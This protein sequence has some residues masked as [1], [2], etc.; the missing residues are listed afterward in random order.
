MINMKNNVHESDIAFLQSTHNESLIYTNSVGFWLLQHNIVYLISSAV[1]RCMTHN[2]G[3]E[4]RKIIIQYSRI[5]HF[6]LI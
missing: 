3:A 1:E 5:F 4:K 6:Q 2:M